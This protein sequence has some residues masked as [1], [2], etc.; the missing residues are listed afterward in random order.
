MLR[1]DRLLLAS[2]LCLFAALAASRAQT[3]QIDRLKANYIAGFID[4][5][6]WERRAPSETISIGV[7]GSPELVSEL[8]RIAS[9][10]EGEQP[11]CIAALQPGDPWPD[12]EVVFVAA[13][14]RKLWPEM[15]ERARQKGAL[16]IGEERGFLKA[17]GAIE[18]RLAKNRLRFAICP[19]NA[20]E[21]SVQ[22]SSKLV[23]LAVDRL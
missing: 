12:V 15:A 13:G 10:R 2:F 5:T 9:H 4:F 11:L 17:G 6:D 23:E 3:L 14:H 21:C 22:L 18:F 16:L 7:I 8:Q 1:L 19:D 20:Q